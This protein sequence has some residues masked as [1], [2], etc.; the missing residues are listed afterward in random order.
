M[1]KTI[2]LS[3]AAA[4][5]LSACAMNDQQAAGGDLQAQLD[6]ANAEN[7]SL[8]SEVASL[9][10]TGNSSIGS[11]ALVPANAKPGECYARVTQPA[12]FKTVQ[13]QVLATEAS[14]KV[15]VIP[16]TYKT[17]TEQV[18]AEEASTRLEVI[19]ATYKTVEER[20]LVRPAGKRV[21]TVPAKFKTVTERIKVRDAYTAWKPGGNVIAV[22]SNALG[23][24]ILQNRTSS[25]GE[26][27]CL[28]EIPAEYRTVSKRVQVS[29]AQTREIDIPAQYKTVKRRVIDQPARTR[30]VNI[31]A[32]FRTV[33]KT[34]EATPASVQRT[35]VPETYKTVTKTI[36]AAPART[37]WTSVLCDVN[38]TPDVVTRMQRALKSAGHYRGPIDGVIGSQT[39][40]AIS[41]Y[42][43]AQGVDSDIL[44]IDSA[45]KLGIL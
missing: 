9:K 7:S 16:A 19:P 28:V 35:P 33:T 17:V 38:T 20:I 12:Q 26:V 29:P 6:A 1:L 39:R 32:K 41:S 31:P 23:G 42:Q 27:M 11:D 22:G 21:E 24:T 2:L 45:K 5:A 44:T 37:V 8:R 30:E 14:E 36:E 34:V 3:S 15:K 18:V 43:S 40:R 10:S 4:V 25:T 13:E